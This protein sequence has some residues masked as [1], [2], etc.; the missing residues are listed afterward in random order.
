MIAA[1]R[2]LHAK[3]VGNAN[4]ISLQARIFH[5]VSLIGIVAISM[6]II[7]NLFIKVPNV[8]IILGFTFL[9][10]AV[11][12]YNSRVLGNLKSSAL[13]F[14]VTTNLLLIANYYYNSGL[15]GP[16]LM[17]CML[18]LIFTVSV[19]SLNR[20]LFWA[21]LNACFVSVLLGLE[22]FYP[23]V[24]KY[25]YMDR[26]GYFIDNLSSYLGAIVCITV[27]LRYWIE[28]QQ[29]EKMKAVLATKALEEANDTKTKLLS[30]L[31]HDLRVP[32]NSIQSFLEMLIDFDLAEDEKKAIK[33]S[34]L[35][36]TKNTQTMLFNLLSWTKSQMDGGV[37]VNLV[38]VNVYDLVA[39]CIAIQQSAATEKAIVINNT[40]DPGID[41]T[42]DSDMLNLVV[43][44][45]LNNA[46]K[47]TRPGGEISI[48]TVCVDD[49]AILTVSDN[50]IGI[51]EDKINQIFS[52]SSVS[53]Y[54]TKNEKGVGLGLLLCKE[55]T[56]LQKGKISIKSVINEGTS[57]SLHFPLVARFIQN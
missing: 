36:E 9:I 16:T 5:E 12:Y 14:T 33:S 45:L 4:H 29:S 38:S 49:E 52:M 54:G 6:A 28:G 50:G 17:L 37:K 1:L 56:E 46:I 26:A 15:R 51:A 24:I 11:L 8:N 55:F 21:V 43:R 34:L 32:L 3:L 18:S 41:V 40:V 2:A 47:F 22:Y 48:T 31:S 27:V 57:F 20:F 13:I 39:S 10:I 53:T 30:I 7:I 19:I 25:T 23:H 42:A 44:N 35:N